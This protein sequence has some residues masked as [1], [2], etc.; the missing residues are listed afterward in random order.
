MSTRPFLPR[1]F[2][3]VPSAVFATL[4]AVVGTLM[5]GAAPA[6][7]D[8][9]AP[10]PSLTSIE[11]ID[12]GVV[13]YFTPGTNSGTAVTTWT[14]TCTSSDGGATSSATNADSSYHGVQVRPL[15][16]GAHYTCTVHATN[17]AGDGA[18][19]AASDSVLISRIPDRPAHLTATSGNHQV[20]YSFD[21]PF[22]GGDPITS[23][24][25]TCGF[26][27]NYSGLSSPIVVPNLPNGVQIVCRME[28]FNDLG[29]MG[30][31]PY[32]AGFPNAI[33][34]AP[35][36]N[37]A[38]HHS[39]GLD[40]AFTPDYFNTV[41]IDSNTATCTSSDGGVDGSATGGAS[42]IFV[43][44]LTI[45]KTYTCTVHA[46]NQLGDSPESATSDPSVPDVVPSAPLIDHVTRG[47]AEI[48][49]VFFAGPDDGSAVI[50]F[51]ATCTSFNGGT[52]GTVDGSSS[53]LLV[54]GLT[55]GKSYTCKVHATND[56]G[57]SA[58]SAASTVVVPDVLPDAPTVDMVSVLSGNNASIDVTAPFPNGG[59]AISSYHGTCTS[60]NGGVTRT[61]S[62]NSSPVA[63][64]GLTLGKTYTCKVAATNGAGTGSAS[65]ASNP[66]TAATAPG[67]PRSANAVSG[68]TTASTGS[69][70]VTFSTPVSDG[71]TAITG[72]AA[73]CSSTNGGV[74]RTSTHAGAS[75][76]AIV[77]GGVT[78]RRDYTCM[79]RAKNAVS[80]GGPL[81]SASPAVIVGSPA[82]PT[83]VSAVRTAAGRIR[84]TFTIGANNGSAITSQVAKCFSAN[85]GVTRSA[86]HDGSAAA[87]I[88][89]TSLTVGKSYRCTVRSINA[90]GAGRESP[91]SA[92]V[93]A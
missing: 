7:A 46:T 18:E 28:A 56:E 37:A 61:G 78:T 1:L 9:V 70:I 15:T 33:P 63:V 84:V 21:A 47:D 2:R 32:V 69:L 93:T 24:R 51:T 66:V 76:A 80:A 60:S 4:I 23:Y 89:V 64:S 41:D 3:A 26:V 85:R 10:A 82:A 40:V 52:P 19:S 13:V 20:S 43:P 53:P 77:V 34:S 8:V 12:N 58:D 6:L 48:S 27:G 88:A 92:P 49:V 38:T 17:G 36:I 71:G 72:Y 62:G 54:G 83:G 87:P 31:G 5:L 75:P 22:D 79:V 39:D 55:N 59:S 35:A 14:A 67:A 86:T 29:A 45:G 50:G 65:D 16:W 11:R 25:L 30:D 68:S 42:P 91:P 57:D 44:F 81:S 74:T 73:T 90:R